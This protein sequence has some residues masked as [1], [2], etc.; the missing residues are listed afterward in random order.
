MYTSNGKAPTWNP[1]RRFLVAL[2]GELI[3][4]PPEQEPR[5]AWDAQAAEDI[6]P[7]RPGA[8]GWDV[9]AVFTWFYLEL[10]L[11]LE[12]EE[13]DEELLLGRAPVSSVT[14]LSAACRCAIPLS[15]CF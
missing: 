4:C 11:E 9:Q 13:S 3:S 14:S 2:Q 7:R 8:P 1:G 6:C 12:P 15:Y 5:I 10:E